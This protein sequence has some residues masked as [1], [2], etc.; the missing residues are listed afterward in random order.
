MS[1]LKKKIGKMKKFSSSD[2]CSSTSHCCYCSFFS[3]LRPFLNSFVSFLLR[4][5]AKNEAAMNQWKYI[6]NKGTNSGC[7]RVWKCQ[8]L[9][10]SSG[11]LPFGISRSLYRL[12]HESAA[13]LLSIMMFHITNSKLSWKT[14][15]TTLATESTVESSVSL[16]CC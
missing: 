15:W 12:S 16:R 11:Q 3:P 5:Q 8:I 14:I 4:P 6:I 7:K 2:L 13:Q 1:C 9:L 10:Q